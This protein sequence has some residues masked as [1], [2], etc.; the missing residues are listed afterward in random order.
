MPPLRQRF[1]GI[2]EIQ[3]RVGIEYQQLCGGKGVITL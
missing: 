1:A 2:L 3:L